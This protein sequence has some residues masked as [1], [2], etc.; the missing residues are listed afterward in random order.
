MGALKA[1]QPITLRPESN[2]R[3]A[4]GLAISP[5]TRFRP[6][7]WTDLI[8]VAPVTSLGCFC[9]GSEVS[10]EVAIIHHNINFIYCPSS[11][12]APMIIRTEG[13]R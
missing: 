13:L 10:M 2:G 11:L 9:H 3:S 1:F 6:L 7:Q 4:S 12:R 5:Q 8:P